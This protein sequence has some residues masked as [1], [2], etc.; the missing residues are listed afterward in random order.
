MKLSI[1]ATIL[2]LC[3]SVFYSPLHNPSLS[4]TPA[5]I[6]LLSVS[7]TRSHA[8]LHMHIKSYMHKVSTSKLFLSAGSPSLTFPPKV[9]RHIT[10]LLYHD[11]AKRLAQDYVFGLFNSPY[12]NLL[13][14]LYLTQRHLQ[15]LKMPLRIYKDCLLV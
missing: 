10:C 14:P 3:L 8:H 9:H 13:Q 5:R 2:Y 7:L 12:L 4:L 11:T 1:R 6:P 15:S